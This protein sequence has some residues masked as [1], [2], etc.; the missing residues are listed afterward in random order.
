MLVAAL[1]TSACGVTA[2]SV[3]QPVAQN[4]LPVTATPAPPQ[5]SSVVQVYLV[6]GGRL[7]PVIRSGRS[8]DD[9]ITSLSAGPTALDVQADLET[10]IP[11]QSVALAAAQDG[12][13]VVE[14]TSAFTALPDRDL[15]LAAAQLVWTAT[16]IC[17]AA[18][19]RVKHDNR[20]LT[21]PTD[22]GAVAGPVGRDDYRSV[23]PA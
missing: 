4:H 13:V 23:A 18:R 20:A 22:R 16:E 5:V 21:L 9:A 6:R 11:P 15:F 14:V 10:R 12:I 19:V 3:P 2:Q 8:T 1:L 7:V 17:C